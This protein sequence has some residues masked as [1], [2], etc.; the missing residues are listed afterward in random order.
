MQ[1]PGAIWL[2]SVRNVGLSA[3]LYHI[4]DKLKQF[5]VYLM[6]NIYKFNY[7]IP[8]FDYDNGNNLKQALSER[9]ET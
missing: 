8:H 6:C 1:Q 3:R 9:L 4:R 5:N 7:K 2:G